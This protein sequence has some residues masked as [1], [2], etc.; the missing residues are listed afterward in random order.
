MVPVAR[1]SKQRKRQR[2]SHH[3]LSRPNLVACPKCS[4][5][6]LPHAACENCGYVSSGVAL[7][8]KDQES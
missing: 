7:V 1:S 4:V 6:K 8:M 2:R 3:A 5:A